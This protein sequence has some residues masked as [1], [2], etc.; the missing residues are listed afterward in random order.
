MEPNPFG[1]W[2]HRDSTGKIYTREE[3]QDRCSGEILVDGAPRAAPVAVVVNDQHAS[4][5]EAGP[6]AGELALGRFVPIGVQPEE[7]DLVGPLGGGGALRRVIAI[8]DRG[9][10]GT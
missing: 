5:G 3:R 1:E 4:A 8:G 2:L 7:R 10:P 6:K 9:P